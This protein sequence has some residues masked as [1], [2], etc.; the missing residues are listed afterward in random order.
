MWPYSQ[1]SSP[2]G[3]IYTTTFTSTLP[4]IP[5]NQEDKDSMDIVV[6]YYY[7]ISNKVDASGRLSEDLTPQ[8]QLLFHF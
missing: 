4:S 3:R 1:V 5:R 6:I 2:Y 8:K 7:L